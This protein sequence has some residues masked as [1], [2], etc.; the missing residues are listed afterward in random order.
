MMVSASSFFSQRHDHREDLRRHD[1]HG[2]LQ[3][4]QG[5]EAPTATGGTGT[6]HFLVTFFQVYCDKFWVTFISMKHPA[7]TNVHLFTF[8]I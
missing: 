8:I 4:E 1:D 2:L 6:F 3:A 7:A 5:Q